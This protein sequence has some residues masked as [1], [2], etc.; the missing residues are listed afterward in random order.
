MLTTTSQANSGNVVPALA[1]EFSIE[2]DGID[3]S[4][5]PLP[6]DIIVQDALEVVAW[7]HFQ[8]DDFLTVLFLVQNNSSE[9]YRRISATVSMLDADNLRLSTE[10]ITS[11]IINILPTQIVALQGTYPLSSYFDGLSVLITAAD[12]ENPQFSANN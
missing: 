1:E 11:S 8:H 3:S 2:A 5:H 6:R 9:T 12:G 7:N 10:N 4:N